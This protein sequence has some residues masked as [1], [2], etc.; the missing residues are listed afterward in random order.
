MRLRYAG[1]C[2]SCA[3]SVPAGTQAGYVRTTRTVRCL[4]CL[5]GTLQS[6]SGDATDAAS[7]PSPTNAGTAGSSARR[8]YERR[9]AK[10]EARIRAAHP[11]LGGLILAVSEEPR[12]TTA[13]AR[14]ARGEELLGQ[15][16]DSLSSRGVRVLHDRRIPKSRANIDHIA[17]GPSGVH[18]ID[19]KRYKGRPALRVEGGIIRPRVHKLM[20]GSRDCT[21]LVEGMHKQL[22]VVRGA[23]ERAGFDDVPVHGA[24]CFVDADWPLFGGSFVIDGIAVLWP[25]KLG[26][27]LV[28]PGAMADDT[29]NAAHSAL[30]GVLPVA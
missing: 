23:L 18:V 25:K 4:A 3:V 19:A 27:R 16:L 8:E 29:I 10:R 24:L 21:R 2:D 7:E 30:A 20:V 17:V 13:W 22:D 6:G 15:A 26:E 12:S 1:T 9:S 28:A 11:R 5:G 14:G